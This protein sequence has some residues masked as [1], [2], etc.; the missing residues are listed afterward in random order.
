MQNAL[1][2]YFSV[3][4]ETP[5]KLKP[6]LQRFQLVVDHLTLEKLTVATLN[7]LHE[8]LVHQ[9]HE[10]DEILSLSNLL[11]EYKKVIGQHKV[12]EKG[13]DHR[14]QEFMEH[15]K[16][17]CLINGESKLYD[18][19][20]LPRPLVITELKKISAQIQEQNIHQDPKSATNKL[21]TIM[22]SQKLQKHEYFQASLYKEFIGRKPHF[23]FTS[24]RFKNNLADKHKLGKV[25]IAHAKDAGEKTAFMYSYTEKVPIPL[26]TICKV[27]QA[28]KFAEV[29]S[30]QLKNVSYKSYDGFFF[31]LEEAAADFPK[32][33][34]F[35]DHFIDILHGTFSN[36]NLLGETLQQHPGQG[37]ESQKKNYGIL[38]IE[39]VELMIFEEGARSLQ[40]LLHTLMWVRI[41]DY[42]LN[43]IVSP[44]EQKKRETEYQSLLKTLSGLKNKSVRDYAQRNADALEKQIYNGLVAK[45]K[46]MKFEDL[47][48]A[49]NGAVPVMRSLRTTAG[50][51]IHDF[52]YFYDY[53]VEHSVPD[54]LDTFIQKEQ[55]LLT[56]F[57][58]IYGIEGIGVD[59]L[60]RLHLIDF[61]PPQKLSLVQGQPQ[62]L[63]N[64]NHL[65]AQVQPRGLKVQQSKPQKATNELRL[66]ELEEQKRKGLEKKISRLQREIS[67]YESGV[68]KKL[69]PE[70][71][72]PKKP[73]EQMYGKQ[74]KPSFASAGFKGW[75]QGGNPIIQTDYQKSS[76]KS[77]Y[78]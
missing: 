61:F 71:E 31:S 35:I 13:N 45:K 48:F 50:F 4:K 55:A 74:I 36:K 7:P 34:Q 1:S 49:M 12:A 57:T 78:N 10:R 30:M 11:E 33:H 32:L 63:K 20:T 28:G 67:E 23:P 66:K 21:I 60:L 41:N 73:K 68:R 18:N 75:F 2:T 72:P 40:C 19:F 46:L 24:R 47:P 27:T 14:E 5:E 25:N 65:E 37:T 54:G 43:Q 62:K 77:S 69:Y 51:T 8:I 9:I 26:V 6:T 38:W 15:F 76:K 52:E 29:T 64:F 3:K 39:I 70:P 17:F 58:E 44:E 16:C 22:R 42:W 59:D 53:H 56:A